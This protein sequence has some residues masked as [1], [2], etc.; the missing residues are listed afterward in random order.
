MS[1]LRIK[2]KEL[3]QARVVPYDSLNP[4][5][6]FRY[7]DSSHAIY[8]AVDEGSAYCFN[9]GKYEALGGDSKVIRVVAE[10]TWRDEI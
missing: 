4:P 2:T 6:L 7:A 5:E 10:V 3:P 9:S 1:Q 8:A